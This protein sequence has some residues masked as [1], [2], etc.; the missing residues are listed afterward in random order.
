MKLINLNKKVIFKTI[1]F[2]T[3]FSIV[4]FTTKHLIS[5]ITS[6]EEVIKEIS[7]KLNSKCPVMINSEIRLDEI[8]EF[9]VQNNF[10]LLYVC[11]LINEDKDCKEFNA[12]LLDKKTKFAAQKDYDSN[13]E[14]EYLRENDLT[15]YYVCYDK[16]KHNLLG[17]EITNQKNITRK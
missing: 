16:N 3:V 4:L 12:L 15:I 9:A 8:D 10:G 1:F 7:S 13:P 2:V 6:T 14:L 17:F 5:S 11:T